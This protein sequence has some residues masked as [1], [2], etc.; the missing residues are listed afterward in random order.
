M[1]SADRPLR[2]L[3]LQARNFELVLP[4]FQRGYVWKLHDIRSFLASLCL[5]FPVGSFLTVEESAD[6]FAARPLEGTTAVVSHVPSK[7]TA[8]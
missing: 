5:D 6:L 8:S 7:K 3:L 2:E 1:P 4:E